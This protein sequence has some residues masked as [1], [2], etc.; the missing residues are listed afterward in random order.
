MKELSQYTN[1]ELQ[2][3]L[4]RRKRYFIGYTS[5][6]IIWGTGNTKEVTESD[7]KYCINDWYDAKVDARE[8]RA[9]LVV[10]ECSEAVYNKVERTGGAGVKFVVRNGM[11]KLRTGK[12]KATKRGAK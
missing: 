6:R 9:S 12:R 10:V 5:D 7:A 2:A 3:E 11:A 1:E 8:A 4:D